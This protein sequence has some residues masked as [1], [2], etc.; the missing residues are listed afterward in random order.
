M[1]FGWKGSTRRATVGPMHACQFPLC[2]LRSR[3][4]I[5]EISRAK[6]TRFVCV[7]GLNRKKTYFRARPR[8]VASWIDLNLRH[9]GVYHAVVAL[10]KFRD[11]RR[12]GR[13]F[14]DP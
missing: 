3:S 14:S 12:S 8:A 6:S 5:N 10:S 1:I 4:S 13:R 2:E 7:Y 9:D 11:F